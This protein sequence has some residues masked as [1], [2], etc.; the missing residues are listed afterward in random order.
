MYHSDMFMVLAL[1]VLVQFK[2]HRVAQSNIYFGKVQYKQLQPQKYKFSFLHFPL[3]LLRFIIDSHSKKHLCTNIR[4]ESTASIHF[5][6]TM[7]TIFASALIILSSRNSGI[8][9]ERVILIRHLTSIPALYLMVLRADMIILAWN[10]LRK[11]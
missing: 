1:I 10:N 9:K 6:N 7:Y 3:P 8:D 5:I 4:F 11:T 2:R